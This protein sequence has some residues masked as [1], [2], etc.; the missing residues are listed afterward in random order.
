MFE[1]PE[2]ATQLL[3]LLHATTNSM[4]VSRRVTV[5]D[6]R[7]RFPQMNGLWCEMCDSTPE[8][9]LKLKRVLYQDGLKRCSAM[10]K[11]QLKNQSK[12]PDYGL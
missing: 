7:F 12:K 1:I 6:D 3:K 4:G 11:P 8:Q 10:K 5:E 2:G 9:Q